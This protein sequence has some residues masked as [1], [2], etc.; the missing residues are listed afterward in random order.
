[1][2]GLDCGALSTVA[3]DRTART[4]SRVARARLGA[5][6]AKTALLLG[7]IA[8]FVASIPLARLTYAGHPKRHSRSLDAPQSFRRS[9]RRDLL[10]AGILA[11]AQAPPDAVTATS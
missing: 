2:C 3:N 5:R 7:G 8:A 6:R 10:S 11:P 9:V 1:M 4:A